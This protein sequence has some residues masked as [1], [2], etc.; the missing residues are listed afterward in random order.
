MEIHPNKNKNNNNNNN[1]VILRTAI[2]RNSQ[3]KKSVWNIPQLL[4]LIPASIGN[5]KF[6]LFTLLHGQNTSSPCTAISAMLDSNG[7]A[8]VLIQ[9]LYHRSSPVIE[10]K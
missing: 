1:E 4:F 2:L 8:F 6:G 9:V 10:D 5:P 7:R 3:S